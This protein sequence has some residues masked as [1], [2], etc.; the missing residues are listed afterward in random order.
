MLKRIIATINCCFLIG[1]ITACSPMSHSPVQTISSNDQIMTDRTN[2]SVDELQNQ[3]ES[4]KEFNNIALKIMTH[5][6]IISVAEKLWKYSLKLDDINIPANGMI[7]IDRT[8][9]RIVLSEKTQAYST[10]PVEIENLGRL[11]E[12]HANGSYSEHFRIV[13]NTPYHIEAT[14]GTVVSSYQY[15]FENISPGSVIELEITSQLQKRLEL[16]TNRIQIL[17]KKA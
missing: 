13:S 11:K 3:L 12:L 5:E 2:Q 16:N 8:N 4:Y 9:F 15:I 10:V 14:S 1:L 17:V 7:E 6:Q